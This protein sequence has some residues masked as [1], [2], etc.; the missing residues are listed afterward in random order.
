LMG[1]YERVPIDAAQRAMRFM[2]TRKN[3][4]ANTS[5]SD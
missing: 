1:V 5:Q 3:I 2:R 4:V